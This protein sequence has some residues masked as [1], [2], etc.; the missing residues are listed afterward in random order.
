MSNFNFL[1]QINLNLR[2]QKMAPLTPTVDHEQLYRS[3]PVLSVLVQSSAYV[4]DKDHLVKFINYCLQQDG[5]RA[6]LVPLTF[7]KFFRDYVN[8]W[9]TQHVGTRS[10]HAVLRHNFIWNIDETLNALGAVAFLSLVRAVPITT[11]LL[12]RTL[13]PLR[14]SGHHKL[15]VEGSPDIEFRTFGFLLFEDNL[16]DNVCILIS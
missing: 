14:R 15:D 10:P 5:D 11:S 3:H 13:P 2:P 1:M 6:S 7:T 4:L 12:Q 8:Y 16:G 9:V